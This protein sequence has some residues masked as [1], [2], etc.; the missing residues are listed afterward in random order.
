MRKGLVTVVLPVY[1]VEPYL[2]QCI[3]SVVA[4]TYPNLEILLIDDG[5]PDR[6]P[7]I[8]DRWAEKDPRIRVI[9]KQN[10]GLGMARNTGIEEAEGEY[11]CFFDSDDYVAED[12]IE[13]VYGLAV[14]EQSELAIFGLK[15]LD[16][17][18]NVKNCFIPQYGYRTYQGKEVQ[19]EFLRDCLGPDPDSGEE[20]FYFSAW[21]FLYSTELIRRSGWRFVSERDIISE[22][23][24]S[25]TALMKDVQRVSVLPE[26][27]YF[28]RF[29]DN[30]LSRSCQ[31]DRYERIR[32]FYMELKALCRKN[33]YSEQVIRRSSHLYFA[34]TIAA[35]KQLILS[36]R[37]ISWK[38]KELRKII[39]DTV[40]QETLH[41]IRNHK[42]SIQRRLLFFAMRQR[43]CGL[44][45]FL[46]A[47]KAHL[48]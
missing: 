4:Q 15:A 39:D 18:G 34:N 10:A 20:F 22:D 9:H 33:L 28:Y 2:D 3:E 46:L 31:S 30:S 42:M 37:S 5:S 45:Y 23:T 1:G 14:K 32:S 38:R 8:C 29:N 41:E 25:L 40:M 47:L 6:C 36:Q 7:E 48:R 13:K 44:T 24:Y 27:L 43:L 35:M 11:I 12:T 26:A 19:E 17:K 21:L 16:A